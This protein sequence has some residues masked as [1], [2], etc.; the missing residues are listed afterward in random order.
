MKNILTV[1][2]L[3][4]YLSL[5]AQYEITKDSMLNLSLIEKIDSLGIDNNYILSKF[6]SEYF[7]AK[8]QKTRENF[9]FTNKKIAFFNSSSGST[10]KS[11]ID[12]FSIEKA[13]YSQN[14]SSNQANLIIFSKKERTETRGYDAVIYYWTKPLRDSKYY[15]KKLR[16]KD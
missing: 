13:R 5:S 10:M 9:D 15:V 2:I 7:N 8:F 11:K 16:N 12:Y 3:F 4:C 1:L 6:E 14:I